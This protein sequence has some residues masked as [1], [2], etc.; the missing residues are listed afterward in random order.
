MFSIKFFHFILP[1]LIHYFLILV[2]SIIPAYSNR[3]IHFIVRSKRM[4][5][6]NL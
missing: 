2:I 5:S 4:G 3:Y 1:Q 6:A